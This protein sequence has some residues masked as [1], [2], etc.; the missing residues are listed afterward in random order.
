[1][2]EEHR[3][4]LEEEFRKHGSLPAFLEAMARSESDAFRHL[5]REI[6]EGPWHPSG[7]DLYSYVLGWIES[8]QSMKILDHIV[9]CGH[10]LEDVIRIRGLEEDLTRD[11]LERADRVPLLERIK[12]FVSDLSFPVFV[13]LP[14]LAPVRREAGEPTQRSFSVDT[15]LTLSVQ[16]PGDGFITIIYACEATG[17]VKLVFPVLETDNPRIAEGREVP[18]IDG[19]VEGPSG[20]HFFKIF[21]TREPLLQRVEADLADEQEAAEA[22]DCF[23]DAVQ[24]LPHEAWRETVYEYEV[25]RG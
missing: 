25:V 8:D 9:M 15:A 6:E 13:Q 21:W 1:M 4:Y 22:V 11:A 23:L 14:A 19:V 20:K 12:R 5:R 2:K 10:C 18:P 24:D 17:E 7:E 16:A 3:T